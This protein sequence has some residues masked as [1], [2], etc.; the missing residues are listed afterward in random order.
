MA[1][2]RP[3]PFRHRVEFLAFRVGLAVLRALPERWALAF[4]AGLG[5][6][7]GTVL[8]IRRDVTDANLARAFPERDQAWRDGVA[9]ASYASI[10]REGVAT[11]LFG[12]E[13]AERVIWRT[14]DPPGEREFMAAAL[15]GR[16]MVAVTGH[17]GN[18]EM[19]GAGAAARGAAIDAV[20]VRQANRLF[21]EAI[22][23]ARA[24]LGVR[25]LRKGDA[26]REALRSL[27]AG[28]VVA[29]VADQDARR[30]GI[31]V[32]FLGTPASTARGPA[33]FA[34]KANVPLFVATCVP[35]PGQP[36]RYL[37]EAEEVRWERSDDLDEDVRRATQAHVAAL[38]A[39]VRR[40]PEHYFWQH[41]RW[42]TAP[43][44]DPQNPP[45]V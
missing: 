41:R 25:I 9:R 6:V 33:L 12:G 4:G 19:A 20:V 10:G 8:R 36:G 30:A 28:R 34:I 18:W 40:Y 42:R 5:W 3:I 38:A 14:P 43:P 23:R 2:L 13:P 26:P 15:S 16:G 24:N 22:S 11:F 29:L 45:G 35:L 1:S 21:D 17:L 32:D 37:A 27:A 44:R 31:F 7:A 39:R